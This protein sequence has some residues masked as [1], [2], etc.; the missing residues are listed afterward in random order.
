M[1]KA[2]WV[3]RFRGDSALGTWLHRITVNGALKR[4]RAEKMRAET[5]LDGLMPVFDG[6]GCRIESL[7]AQL[8]PLE[9]L[10]EQREVREQVRAAISR[11]PE[12]YRAEC[13]RISVASSYHVP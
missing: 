9:Q 11:L 3:G 10:V 2:P 8:V 4:L 6:S 7:P 5:E 13:D 12:S 1:P